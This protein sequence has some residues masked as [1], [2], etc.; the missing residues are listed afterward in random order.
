MTQAENGQ[1]E[2]FL[3][4]EEL[5]EASTDFSKKVVDACMAFMG[6]LV[7]NQLRPYQEP[8]AR[9]VFE[10]L[11]IE[12]A[13]TITALFSRQSGKSETVTNVVATAMVL[14][15]RLAR[16][17]PDRMGKYKDGLW[18]GIFAPVEEQAETIFSR[19]V[20]RLTS[21]TAQEVLADPEVNDRAEGR[22]GLVKL[23]NC[24]SFARMMTANPRAKIE[25]KSY[26]L[27]LLDETQEMDEYVVNKSIFPM[28]AAYAGTCVMTGTPARTKGVF[29]KQIQLNK[30]RQL[31]RNRRQNHFQADWKEVAKWNPQYKKSVAKDMERMGED[32][33]EFQMSY[34]L[35]WMLERGMFTTETRLDE[36]GDKSQQE[37]VKAY[38]RTPVVVGI[39]PARTQD[40][41]V[42]TV[43]FVDWDRQDEFGYY[44]HRILNWMEL[45]GMDWE[46][47]YFQIQRF[48]DPY[49][50]FAVGIDAQGVGDA[51]AQRLAILL[52]N[53]HC[54]VVP[55]K[56][57]SSD[58]SARWKH[59]M[60]LMDRGMVGWPAGAK[61]RRLRSYQRFIQ[62]MADA[63]KVF[64]GPNIL[65]KAPDERGAHD[66][67][68]DSL[69]L[70]TWLTAD[71]TAPSVEV[72]GN[73]F[74]GR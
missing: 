4:D 47:Q 7:E 33:D 71:L 9:R 48:L 72:S 58:Q 17:F 6:V 21:E 5:D 41:T 31:E 2:A 66:D 27:V 15:P 16:M 28:M 62:Q 34:C 39:D 22:G 60:A 51:V 74:F 53:K 70:A 54:D 61:V 73:P 43:V 46:E 11:V 35:K 19:L 25:S 13:E 12:D 50:I 52:R 38:N 30:R 65:I 56:S 42:V 18:V 69:A 23:L 1:A 14:F 26:H 32:S 55:L 8:F 49:N 20:D 40:S 3:Q 59:L 36:L 68:V 29:Y 57:N 67:Y 63:E 10:S 45:V 64:Q 37:L 44:Q 24:K